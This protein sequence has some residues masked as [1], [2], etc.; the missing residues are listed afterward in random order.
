MAADGPPTG[1]PAAM[2]F[3]S[4]ERLAHARR[5]DRVPFIQQLEG[6]DCGAACLAMVL[7]HLGR[8]VALDE[9]REAAGGSARDGVDARAIVR[10]AEWFGLRSRALAIDVE[11]LRYLPRGSVLHWE[12]NHFVV[13]ERVTRRG[14]EIVDPATGP[15]LVTLAKVREAFTGV[16]L[17]FAQGNGF[18]PKR[19]NHGHLGWYLGQLAGQRHVL[20]RIV[21]TSILLRVFALALPVVT[22]LIVDRVVPH[23]DHSLLVAI[24]I[25]LGGLLVFLMVTTLV[26]SH[27][28]LQLRTNLDVRLTLDFVD[29]LSR[30]PY[31]FFQRRSAG[32][33]MM[34][35]NSN[36]TMRELLTSSSLSALLDGT[37]VVGYAV[38]V[39]VIAP[40]IGAIVLG[41]GVLQIA[42]LYI[43]RREYRGLMSR[44]LDAQAR[45]QSY[46]IEM[47]HGI[48]TLKAAAAE[49]RAVE[50]W[51]NLYVDELNVA[52]DR[53][54]LTARVDAIGSVLTT[55][56]PLL[57]L[58]I[59]ALQVMT[60]AISMGEM[61][62]IN[63]L[64]IGLLSPLS[65]LVNNVLQLQMLGSFKDRID[66]VLRTPLEQ[67]GKDFSRTPKLSGGVTLQNVSFRY[68]DNLP[69]VIREVSL[70]IRAGMKVAIVG[71][72]GCGKSTL[73]NMIAGLYPPKEGRVLFDGHDLQH[74]E[75]KSLRQQIG[76]VFQ[77]PSLFAG[78]IRTAISLSDPSASFVDIREAARLAAVDDD[79]RAM[80]M[81]YDTVIA[82][83]G[84]SLSG[85]QRQRIALARA[86]LHR[87][88]LLILDEAT[89]ALD[90]ETERRVIANL[91]S[92]R[93]TQIVLAH[94]LSTIIHADLILVMDNGM[95]VETG[96][97]QELLARSEH[98]NRLVAPQLPSLVPQSRA[99]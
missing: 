54:R 21:V 77:S 87:P 82:D 60:G 18:E 23:D 28:L 84:A 97:H 74:L 15:R 46:L 76:F 62:A 85:G 38:L 41:L 58:M 70:D 92:L 71:H 42:V 65:T 64:A 2:A 61:L 47:L 9:V 48:A 20:R 12:F 25:G 72:S 37:L 91:E 49:A 73:A 34:R 11:Q 66:D 81:G 5:G 52:L 56:S 10:A 57:V 43:A 44:S 55:G 51:S 31:N 30:L 75:L 99:G 32:D 8:D 94:R 96:T 29:Y 78:S 26:R 24:A 83:R 88:P 16:A 22:A 69:F 50:R 63:A 68:G 90:S 59:G 3:P 53:G 36:A 45:S 6:T 7:G 35:V 39:L 17:V 33:L 89:S 80:P 1:A 93:C 27:L 4:L 67:A 98:Y 79:I 14:V 86:L 19:A 13:F 95:I 40:V